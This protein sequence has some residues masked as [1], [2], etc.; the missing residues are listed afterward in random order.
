MSINDLKIAHPVETDAI[1]FD[2]DG[3]L[4]GSAGNMT[5]LSYPPHR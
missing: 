1:I 3:T 5:A 2:L 4:V